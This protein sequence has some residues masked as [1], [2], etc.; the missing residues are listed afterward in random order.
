[1]IQKPNHQTPAQITNKVDFKQ[2]VVKKKVG[3]K[4]ELPWVAFLPKL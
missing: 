3:M 4:Y 1:V 2:K